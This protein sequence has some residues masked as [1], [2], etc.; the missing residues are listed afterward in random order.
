ML[1]PQ[2]MLDLSS[3]IRDRTHTPCIGRQTVHHWTTRETLRQKFL[4]SNSLYCKGPSLQSAILFAEAEGCFSYSCVWIPEPPSFPR[5]SF[6]LKPTSLV[7][8]MVRSLPAM[9]D[10][11]VRSVGGEDPLEKGMTTHSSILAWRIP[12][13][14][15]PCKLQSMGL[16]RV[17]HD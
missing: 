3:S 8:H 6:C 2:G 12:W 14:E 16:Q 10:T 11:Q 17:G 5:Q 1:W 7:A 4:K 15:E 9:W 13:M